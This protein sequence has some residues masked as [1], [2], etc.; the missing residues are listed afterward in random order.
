MRRVVAAGR[1]RTVL[2]LTPDLT[3]SADAR[4][5]C[6]V[7][8][9]RGVLTRPNAASSIAA[10]KHAVGTHVPPRVAKRPAASTAVP[11]SSESGP[12]Q[13]RRYLSHL[14]LDACTPSGIPLVA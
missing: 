3:L 9:S 10:T 14:G 6:L 1:E 13:A 8:H 5:S 4:P 2:D 7:G 11:S 12:N